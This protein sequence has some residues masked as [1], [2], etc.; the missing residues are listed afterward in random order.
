MTDPATVDRFTELRR[1][2]TELRDQV[3]AMLRD[4]LLNETTKGYE[5]T[6]V[7]LSCM[8]DEDFLRLCEREGQG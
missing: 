7:H 6:L 4:D 8:M 5:W 3:G 2:L 1:K